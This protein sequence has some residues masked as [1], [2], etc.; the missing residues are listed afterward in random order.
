MS[1]LTGNLLGVLTRFREGPIAVIA[2]IRAMFHQVKVS[3]EDRDSLR[4]FWWEVMI[5]PLP[6]KSIKCWSIFLGPHPPQAAVVL[7]FFRLALT[8]WLMR[9][10]M[11]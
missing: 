5:L 1:D 10:I 11:F 2:N 8:T 3:P 7:L 6:L 9:T 4:F